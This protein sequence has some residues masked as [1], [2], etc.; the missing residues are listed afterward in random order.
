MASTEVARRS[1]EQWIE[2]LEEM[3]GRTFQAPA[4]PLANEELEQAVDEALDALYD[5]EWE[6]GW[7][8]VAVALRALYGGAG[9]PLRLPA[10]ASGTEGPGRT[11]TMR[12][13]EEIRARTGCSFDAAVRGAEREEIAVHGAPLTLCNAARAHA[14][15]LA[16][17]YPGR[18]FTPVIEP[19][20][21]CVR[22][23][24]DAA[25]PAER[26]GGPSAPTL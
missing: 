23:R 5:A 6:P 13:A 19:M 26:T 7:E 21:A 8:H 11:S 18:A 2:K 3:T 24:P 25:R 16:D 22:T 1:A 4:A 15:M 14:E 17:L 10:F 12:R 9:F 20:P